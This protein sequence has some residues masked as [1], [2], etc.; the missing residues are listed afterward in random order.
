M[1]TTGGE[2]IADVLEGVCRE[3]LD[4]RNERVGDGVQRA[5]GR[6]PRDFVDFCRVAAAAGAW[7]KA[8]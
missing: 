3:T 6:E 5:L 7:N 8:A 2:L 1:Q 4:G